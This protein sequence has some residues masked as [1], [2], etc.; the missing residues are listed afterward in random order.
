MRYLNMA[1]ID[2]TLLGGDLLPDF[3]LLVKAIF[4]N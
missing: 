2:D 4:E 1:A 3:E